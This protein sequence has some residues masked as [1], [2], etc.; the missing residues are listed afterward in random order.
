MKHVNISKPFDTLNSTIEPSSA[1]KH[2]KSIT[3]TNG[4]HLF[5]LPF[6]DKTYN[7]SLIKD[8]DFEISYLNKNYKQCLLSNTRSSKSDILCDN[9]YS[10]DLYYN[11]ETKFGMNYSIQKID[12]ISAGYYHISVYL[13]N[14]GY[15]NN[16]FILLIGF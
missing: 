15:A 16:L 9:P 11:D 6:I 7:K 2:N 14:R 3:A 5:T 10:G 1:I 13:E 12:H 8:G 4:Y